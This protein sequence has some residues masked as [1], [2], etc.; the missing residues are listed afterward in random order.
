MTFRS[1]FG[2][3]AAV[4]I[5]CAA[6]A[7]ALMAGADA[8]D[9]LKCAALLAFVQNAH[10]ME[11]LAA[12]AP[13]TVGVLGRPAF[14]RCLRTSIEG[15]AV[16]G[17]PLRVQEIRASADPRC[18]QVLYFATDQPSEIRLALQSVSSQRVLTVGETG[19]F[20]EQGG[21]VNLFLMDGHMAF[22]VSMVAL[23][24]SGITISSKLLRFGQIRDL[25]KGRPFK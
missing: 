11:P 15:K 24:R 7:T 5:F 17:R 8:E 14:L 1:H 4:A 9:E 19:H 16:D 18:C 21:A 10:W 12:S 6:L 3:I 13:L 20:L 2:R 25:A 22:E 23:D